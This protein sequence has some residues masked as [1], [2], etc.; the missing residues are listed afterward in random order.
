MGRGI[1]ELFTVTDKKDRL[2]LGSDAEL[3]TSRTEFEL[4]LTQMIFELIQT[5]ILIAVQVAELSSKGQK[6]SLRSNCLQNTA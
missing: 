6:Y 2:R 5:L 1:G 4:R 3:F